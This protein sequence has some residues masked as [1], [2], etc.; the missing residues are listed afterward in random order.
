MD[1]MYVCYIY[2][3]EMKSLVIHGLHVNHGYN[4]TENI[5]VLTSFIARW[6]EEVEVETFQIHGLKVKKIRG[7]LPQLQ[8]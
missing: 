6:M 5:Y 7:T 3:A 4:I 1:D 2:R 8:V